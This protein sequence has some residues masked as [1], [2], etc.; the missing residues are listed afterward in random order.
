VGCQQWGLYSPGWLIAL[1]T[2]WSASIYHQTSQISCG[3]RPTA[4]WWTAPAAT[5]AR[6]ARRWSPPRPGWRG[7]PWNKRTQ[8][9][10]QPEV[11]LRRG[12]PCATTR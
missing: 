1:T 4:S 3:T 10:R 6:P 8:H 11:W 2:S 5:P 12:R 9:Q 7:Y